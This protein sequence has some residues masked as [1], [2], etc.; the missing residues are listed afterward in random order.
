MNKITIYTLLFFLLLIGCE[1]SKNK[2][3]HPTEENLN[4]EMEITHKIE[5]ND[6]NSATD[7]SVN[8][9]IQ[10]LKN[11][12]E[13]FSIGRLEGNTYEMFGDVKDAI[14]SEDL[15]LLLVLDSQNIGINAYNLSGEYLHQI[16][17]EGRGPGE[18]INPTSLSVQ[19]NKSFVLN[20]QF[21]IKT[22]KWQDETF[23]ADIPINTGYPP[24]DFCIMEDRIY[25]N[26]ITIT[27][28]TSMNENHHNIYAYEIE[29]YDEPTLKF[30]TQYKSNSWHAIFSMSVG[31]GISCNLSSNTVLQFFK[32]LN[33][34]YGY[35]NGE[36]S[37]VSRIESFNPLRIIEIPGESM[38]PDIDNLQESYDTIEQVVSLPG[39][40]FFLVQIANRS[41]VRD[42]NDILNEIKTYLINVLNGEGY[43][44]SNIFPQIL[45]ATN[46]KL[47][48]LQTENFQKIS[49]SEY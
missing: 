21:D 39:K 38:G 24:L 6:N 48:F 43:Y 45:S 42:G 29:S 2:I 31:A 49:I 11:H 18:L 26:S 25:I 27:D 5:E 30:G 22:Y 14:I 7:S 32:F 28:D 9:L 33:V 47:V 40:D 13:I 23:S 3:I 15:D 10:D 35:T 12:E 16:S 46:N 44:V 20:E 34:L 36:L 17:R 1:N 37:W 8:T 19:G 41:M 4:P